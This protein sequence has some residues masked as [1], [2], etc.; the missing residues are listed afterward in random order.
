MRFIKIILITLL[1]TVLSIYAYFGESAKEYNSDN[2]VVF[3]Y[4]HFGDSRYP[5]T[6]IRLD[7]FEY[8]LD[9]L[10]KNDYNI[11]PLSKLVEY[12]RNGKKIPSKTVSLTMDDAYISVFTEAYP[13]LKKRNWPFTVF[14]NSTPIDKKFKNFMSWEQM[15]EMREN[16]AEFANHS[17]SHDVMLPKCGESK[18]V[19][20][21]RITK[22][23]QEAQKRLQEELGDGTNENPKLFSYPYGEYNMQTAELISKLGYVGIAQT[24]GPVGMESDFRALPRFA[25]AEAF[26]DSDGFLLKL[27]TKPLPIYSVSPREPIV[28]KENPPILRM[29]LKQHLKDMRCYLSS[30]EEVTL[31]WIS[32]T[33]VKIQAKR[34]LNPP[35][36]RYTC[37]ARVKDKQ[38]YWYSHFWI[39]EK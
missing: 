25:M 6:N 35:R 39:I 3:M 27:Q 38:Y 13:R 23:V 26:A 36:D 28:G 22:E 18:T 9:Y 16:G 17:L 15:R 10:Q 32:K 37:T 31:D 30:G 34:P 24:S 7:Q 1:L 33:E 14:V 21:T 5:S 12:L 4:H 29:K 2:A 20:A 11:W 8:H 19:C